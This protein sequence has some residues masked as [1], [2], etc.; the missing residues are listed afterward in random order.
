VDNSACVN[1]SNVIAPYPS[2]RNVEV[3]WEIKHL[4]K[5]EDI[6]PDLGLLKCIGISLFFKGLK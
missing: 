5:P 6:D 1:T 4:E 2:Q 3:D